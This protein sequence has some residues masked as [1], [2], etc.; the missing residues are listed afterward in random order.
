MI[1][2][3][4]FSTAT[5]T[6]PASSQT[7]SA[8]QSGVALNAQ[9]ARLQTE[10]SNCVNCSTANTLDGKTKIQAVTSQISDIKARIQQSQ[11]TQQTSNNANQ[12]QKTALANSGY[13]NA[14]QNQPIPGATAGSVINISA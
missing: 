8:A 1:P 3:T 5:A 12:P 14:S 2:A 10:L 4:S 9:L 11:Q 13:Q 7:G 6:A